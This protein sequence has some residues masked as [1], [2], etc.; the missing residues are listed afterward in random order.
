MKQY[1]IRGG[2]LFGLGVFLLFHAGCGSDP[3]SSQM[4]LTSTKTEIP[5][6]GSTTAEII[7]KIKDFEGNPAN[8]GTSVTFTTSKGQFSNGQQS[9]TVGISSQEDDWG[10]VK[11]YFKAALKTNPGNAQITCTSN[12]VSRMIT[13][14][15][16]VYGP[17]GETAKIVLT[18]LPVSIP[19]DGA[20]PSTITAGPTA[21]KEKPV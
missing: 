19:A 4:E 18:A 11:V 1:Y 21:G 14:A 2:V 8:I 7:A 15:I 9:I 12:D 20:T 5:A 13:I 17:P 16:A 3:M 10:V 6:D